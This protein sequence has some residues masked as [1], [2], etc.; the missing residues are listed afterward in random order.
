MIDEQK[1]KIEE[2][3][4]IG[5]GYRSIALALGISRDKVRNYCKAKCLDGYGAEVKKK[6]EEVIYIKENCKNCCKRINEEPKAG[7]PKAYCSKEYKKAWEEKNPIMYRKACYYCGK[8]LETIGSQINDCS[9]KCYFRN[10]FWI[11][12]D[13]EIIMEHIEKGIPIKNATGW[14]KNLILG[15]K[16]NI[17]N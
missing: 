13:L 14:I 8:N 16:D 6:F 5:I 17:D 12:A 11:H 10:S 4:K 9:H 2:L 15:F 1:V 3:R 7:C